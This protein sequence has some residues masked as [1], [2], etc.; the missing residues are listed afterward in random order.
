MDTITFNVTWNAGTHFTHQLNNLPGV[1]LMIGTGGVGVDTAV[2][3]AGRIVTVD[4]VTPRVTRV[5]DVPPTVAKFPGF[6]M[7]VIPL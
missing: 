2:V 7:F 4:G 1:N 3:A 5:R 6:E